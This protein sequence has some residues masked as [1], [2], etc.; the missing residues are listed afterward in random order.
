MYLTKL[1]TEVGLDELIQKNY[2]KEITDPISTLLKNALKEKDINKNFYIEDISKMSE[3]H[4]KDVYFFATLAHMLRTLNIPIFNSEMVLS[5]S[6]GTEHVID[7]KKLKHT[8]E[9]S[10]D[11]SH[12]KRMESLEHP[13]THEMIKDPEK[14]MKFRFQFTEDFKHIAFPPKIKHSKIKKKTI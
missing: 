4:Y 11:L 6:D 7:F 1:K 3:T 10:S 2:P 14:F 12:T 5:D 9:E 13:V 8:Y